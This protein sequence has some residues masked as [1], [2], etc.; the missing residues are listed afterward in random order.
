MKKRLYSHVVPIYQRTTPKNKGYVF[1]HT[2]HG[3]NTEVYFIEK[4]QGRARSKGRTKNRK[5]LIFSITFKD[6]G[7]SITSG[8]HRTFPEEFRYAYY[9]VDLMEQESLEEF[10]KT[11]LLI[12]KNRLIAQTQGFQKEEENFKKTGYWSYPIN[13]D[14]RIYKSSNKLSLKT[15][16][17]IDIEESDLEYFGPYK[18]ATGF[19]LE[20]LI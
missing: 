10:Y 15:L 18:K 8:V 17:T 6:T 16:K 2:I 5:F 20:A 13:T 14:P 4:L 19:E 3:E 9:A 11:A 1:A 7:L 12:T